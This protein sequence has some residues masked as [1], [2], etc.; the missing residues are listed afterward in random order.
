MSTGV[1][2]AICREA[3]RRL[4][5]FLY[6]EAGSESVRT[7][8]ALAATIGN[9]VRCLMPNRMATASGRRPD[10]T[11]RAQLFISCLQ[12]IGVEETDPPSDDP[13]LASCVRIAR[14]TLSGALSDPT[15]GATGFR[16]LGDPPADAADA[17]AGVWIGSY[18][19][20]LDPDTAAM[21]I[22]EPFFP[23]RHVL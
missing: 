9:R 1:D 23:G 21:A 22:P 18:L 16:R 6:L 17:D 15:R 12:G 20:L 2:T 3:V 8:E 7:R 13:V 19:F 4:A 5:R 11:I 10:E 14:R